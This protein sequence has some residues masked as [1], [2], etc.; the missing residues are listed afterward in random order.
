MPNQRNELV[1]GAIVYLGDHKR[2]ILSMISVIRT[3][4]YELFKHLLL[5]IRPEWLLE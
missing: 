3:A 5:K 2:V 1:N 4:V